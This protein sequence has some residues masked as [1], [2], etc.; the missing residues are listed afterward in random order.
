MVAPGAPGP[1]HPGAR[2]RG[3]AHQRAAPLSDPCRPVPSTGSRGP[4]P[5]DGG[6]CPA[7][8]PPGADRPGR[9]GGAPHA[10]ADRPD[11]AVAPSADLVAW[12][13]LGSAYDPAELRR[14]AGRAAG[15]SSCR[16]MIRPA[17]DIALFRA[18]MAAWPG[19]GEL[20]DW[21]EACRD[22]VRGQR[23][24]AAPTS[25][26]GCAR[27]GPLPSRALPD[28]CVRAVAVERLD[29]QPERQPAARPDGAARR[30]RRRRPARAATGCGT[31]PSGSTPTTPPVP[32]DEAL[33]IRDE[34]R[35]RALGIARAKATEVPGRAERRRRGRRAGRG[36]GGRGHLAG[37]PGATSTRRSQGRAALLSPFDRLVYDRKRMAELFEFDYQLEMYKP[38]RQ[39]A[40]GLLR[41]ADPA[42][43]PAG[44]QAR[45]DRRPQG[46]GAAG[47]RRPRGRAVHADDGRRRATREIEE[48]ARW[49]E[50][51]LVEPRP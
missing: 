24:A 2:P 43:R 16:G 20:R 46:R 48:L 22:W 15:W 5:A 13:R 25:S 9:A 34:R 6:P 14:R 18:E 50:L 47:R 8:G 51:E 32:A 35:L 27:D 36:R 21:Q 41:A 42:R 33:R 45:R 28:T 4:T 29:Q 30:G 38:A 44:R 49:L 39:A 40:L 19:S 11:A 3:L 37:R 17:E 1:A 12:S 10:A 26:S 23:R 7:A 31:S